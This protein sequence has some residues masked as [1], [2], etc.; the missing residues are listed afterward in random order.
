M[1]ALKR[2]MAIIAAAESSAA[3]Q[4]SEV[5][6]GKSGPTP[7]LEPPHLAEHD[8]QREPEREV[9]DHADHGGGDR[10]QRRGERLLPRSAST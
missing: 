7:K 3:R 6:I 9:Q 5:R 1:P 4:S 10:R 2:S 8:M